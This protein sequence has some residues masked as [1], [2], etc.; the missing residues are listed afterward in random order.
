MFDL[1]DRPLH[2]LPFKWPGLAPDPENENALSK[3]VEH[4]IELRVELVTKDE[5][6]ELFPRMF[7]DEDKPVLPEL[8]IFKRIVK[9][10]RK[11]KHGGR[12]PEFS[13]E[14]IS[15]LLQAPMFSA[16]FATTYVA[17]VGGK[18][19]I[20]E[21]NSDGSP[22]GGRADDPKTATTTSSSAIAAGSE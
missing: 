22:S 13:D 1:L 3:P 6:V 19:D 2:W 21:G 17:A 20:R 7:G 18:V 12:V 9:G 16:S 11:I 5:L 8:E 4:E 15:L 14:N 10:W